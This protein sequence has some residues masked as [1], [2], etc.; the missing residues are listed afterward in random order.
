MLYTVYSAVYVLYMYGIV[1]VYVF[2]EMP[3]GYIC[4]IICNSVKLLNTHFTETVGNSY[5]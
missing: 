4:I 2:M 3:V 5:Q 1:R